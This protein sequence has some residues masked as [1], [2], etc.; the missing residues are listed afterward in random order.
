MKATKENIMAGHKLAD[1]ALERVS[2]GSLRCESVSYCVYC[3]SGHIMTRYSGV[4][5]QYNNMTYNNCERYMCDVKKLYFFKVTNND[6]KQ[7][8]L[9]QMLTQETPA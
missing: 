2:G 8:Y 9:D 1:E 6:G 5:V 3:H 4:V 7:F